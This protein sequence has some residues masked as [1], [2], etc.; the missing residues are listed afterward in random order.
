MSSRKLVAALLAIS[1]FHCSVAYAA[2][3]TPVD[4]SGGVLG[5]SSDGNIALGAIV[6]SGN[7][8]AAYWT[9][10]LGSVV[11]GATTSY[12]N[13]ASAGGA[14]IVGSHLSPTFPDFY[15][16]RWLSGNPNPSFIGFGNASD[17]TDDGAT[18]V[19]ARIFG[20]LQINLKSEPFRYTEA[21][22]LVN[23]GYL[24]GATTQQ[25][26][27]AAVTPDGTVIVGYAASANGGSEAFRWT[28]SGGMVGLGDLPGGTFNSIAVGVSDDG[29]VIAGRGYVEGQGIDDGSRGFY[30]TH[31]SGLTNL[32]Q[33]RVNAISGDGS[34]I[35]GE[36]AVNN[37]QEA[38]IWNIGAGR[39][40]LKNLL[41]AQGL[42]LTGWNISEANDV[43]ADGRVIVGRARTPQNQFVG[44]VAVIPEPS[45]WLMAFQVAAIAVVAQRCRA[46]K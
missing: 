8:K 20:D 6:D 41:A 25:G 23:L 24:P 1:L 36:A 37:V 4:F 32:G 18:V 12:A 19:G 13:A 31:A 17:V 42:D 10:A 28:Q 35:V 21:E 44:F 15:A 7:P 27:A 22:G 34:V 29:S 40:T 16:T 38:V 26:G 2:K 9:E 46:R 39:H 43:S 45:Q 33:G 11:L 30:W 5:V 14:V 3:F